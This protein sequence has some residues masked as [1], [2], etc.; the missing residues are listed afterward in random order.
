MH[1]EPKRQQHA[2]TIRTMV[3][4]DAPAAAK[5]LQQAP[6]A[7]NWT[8][9]S[10]SEVAAGPGLALV[11]ERNGKV[12]GFLVARLAADE[13]E[14]LNLAVLPAHRRLGV[15]GTLLDNALQQFR[16][17]G[18]SR[19]FLEVRESNAGAIAFYKRHG[20]SEA[21]RRKTYYRAPEEA[22]VV[23]AKQLNPRA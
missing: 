22:A 11:S 10:L 2:H 7:A 17:R 21:G 9:T 20:F 13:A 4:G 15:A 16:T 1:A 18:V 23:M 19:L 3:P 12:T 8:E 6:E 14:I 5:I